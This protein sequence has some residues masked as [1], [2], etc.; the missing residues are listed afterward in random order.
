M[1]N[2][3]K[4]LSIAKEHREAVILGKLKQEL[5]I[6]S[7]CSIDLEERAIRL[8]SLEHPVQLSRL[9]KKDFHLLESE[10]NAPNYTIFAIKK[11]RGGKRIVTAPKGNTKAIQQRL[12]HFFQGYYSIIR[13]TAS[14][15]FVRASE[16]DQTPPSIAGNAQPHVGQ[17][18]LYSLDLKDYFTHITTKQVYALFRSELFQFNK[19]IAQAMTLLL[20]YNGSLP[21]GAP[22]SPVI[23]NFCT[24]QLDDQLMNFA[25]ENGLNYTR[26]ADDMTFSSLSF[27]TPETRLSLH[28]LI[29]SHGFH[30]HPKKI[31]Y[32]HPHQQHRVTGVIVNEKL[33]VDRKYI[34]ITRAMVHDLSA[35]GLAIAT[36]NHFRLQRDPFH[37]EIT[38][39][40][41]TLQGRISFIQSIRG[42]HDPNTLAYQL[43]LDFALE[44]FSFK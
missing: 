23:A 35:N 22:T 8:L 39:F 31:H 9:L 44:N 19:P 16:F 18:H 11:K 41:H 17:P 10:I 42:K 14:Y 30:I 13:P 1:M 3:Q 40:I 2:S 4:L 38:R 6:K 20:T 25:A 7:N 27:I 36:Q 29:E 32:R 43:T 24:F 12:N 28:Q 33:N 21:T 15:G 37:S 26:Y 5:F 34:K